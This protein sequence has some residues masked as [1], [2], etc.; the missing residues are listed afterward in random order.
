[1]RF[2]PSPRLLTLLLLGL[3]TASALAAGGSHEPPY[4][5]SSQWS[6]FPLP[7][8]HYEDGGE[9]SATTRIL[10]RARRSPFN[11]AATAVF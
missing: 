11:V 9:L 5:D 1:M 6:R 4:A 10:E 7:L 8:S 3:M 2:L